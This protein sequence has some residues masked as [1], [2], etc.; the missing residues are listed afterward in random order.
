M[1][2]RDTSQIQL[3]FSRPVAVDKLGADPVV[4]EIKAK[5]DELRAL[6]RRFGIVGM[7]DLVA[8]VRLNRVGGRAVRVVGRFIADVEQMCVVT[9]EAF[10]SRIE[11]SYTALFSPD[12]AQSEEDVEIVVD[13]DAEEDLPEPLVGGRIDI[14]ELTAQHLSLALDPYPRRPG[15]EFTDHVEDDGSA[16]EGANPFA[17]LARL[18][19]PH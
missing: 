10:Q 16:D 1:N 14:G 5:P 17:A 13:P 3:E 8:E 9:L 4:R 12:V 6:T 11:E 7:T 18:N 15:V 2:E 19:R